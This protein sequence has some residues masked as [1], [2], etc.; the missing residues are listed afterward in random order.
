[1]HR[2]R[3]LRRET[4]ELPSLDDASGQRKDHMARANLSLDDERLIALIRAG[5]LSAFET[6][7]RMYTE[8]LCTFAQYVVGSRDIAAEIVQDVFL[9]I[10]QG[11][12]DVVIQQSIKAY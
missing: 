9:R 12:E 11:R 8:S 3:L 2:M 5:D 1:M 6:V 10:W 7:F 4:P